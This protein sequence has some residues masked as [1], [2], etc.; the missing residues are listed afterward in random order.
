MKP[1]SVNKGIV[2]GGSGRLKA[3]VLAVG[4]SA[5]ASKQ[6]SPHDELLLLQE[7]LRVLRAL[8]EEQSARIP[9]AERLKQAVM[10]VEE[11]ARRERPSGIAMASILE[12]IA[13]SAKSV[14][15][16]VTAAVD[17]KLLVARL[18]G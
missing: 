14:T 15:A 5:R 3:D 9:D 7:Q 10:A 11:E 17:L 2:I 1:P 4:D 18:F 8:I 6:T 13:K 16:V 12:N